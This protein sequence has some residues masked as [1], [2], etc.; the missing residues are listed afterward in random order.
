MS[1]VSLLSLDYGTRKSGIAYSVEGF[2]FAYGTLRTDELVAFLTQW[3]AQKN[4]HGIV[5]GL[6]LHIDGSESK[7]SQ[8]VRQFAKKLEQ[9]FPD[10]QIILHD[11]R[12]TTSEARFA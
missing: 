7:H 9:I 4:T 12:L 3:I 11:E 8:R 10:Q 5:I 6:P 1:S 2:C